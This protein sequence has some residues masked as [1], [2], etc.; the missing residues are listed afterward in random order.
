VEDFHMSIPLAVT[1]CGIEVQIEKDADGIGVL[2]TSVK[3]Q[4][5]R[6]VKNGSIVGTNKATTFSWPGAET[7]GVYGG[8][9]DLW[10]TTWTSADINDHEFGIAFSAQL[11]SGLTGAF[12]AANIDYITIN[13]YYQHITLAPTL[14]FFKGSLE[15]NVAHLQWKLQ[16]HHEVAALAVEKLG[17][18]NN[19]KAFHTLS[20]SEIENDNR[21][22]DVYD[23]QLTSTNTYRLKI[24]DQTGITTYSGT[25]TIKAKETVGIDITFNNRQNSITIQSKSPIQLCRLYRSDGSIYNHRILKKLEKEVQLSIPDLRHGYLIVQVITAHQSMSKQFLLASR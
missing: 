17:F 2:G 15:R 4:T 13:V 23:Q 24:T 1:I 20:S 6:L 3:D 25:I 9:G 12:L 8:N 19:W 5:V 16:N 14:D 21:C 22:Y 18:G 11:N 10:G 7:T